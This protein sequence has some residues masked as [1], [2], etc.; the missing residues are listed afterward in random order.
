[1]ILRL[2]SLTFI[3][4]YL[5]FPV[6]A[7]EWLDE[8]DK[9]DL[10][11]EWFR[12]TD[13][14]EQQSIVEIEDGKLLLNEPNGNFGH[15]EV[16]GRPLVLRK[17]PEGDF[18]IS[19][20]IDTEPPSPAKDY[21]IGLFIIGK[22]GDHPVLAENWAILTIGGVAGDV[23]A[24]IG[25]M[26]NNVWNDKGHFGIPEWPIYLKLDKVGIQ[27]TGYYKEK[28]ADEWTM[29]GASWNHDGMEEPELCGLGFVN[30]WGGA[31]LTLMAEYFLLEGEN[32]SS[33]A[34]QPMDK[35]STAWGRIKLYH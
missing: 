21:W 29:V 12:I 10:D 26:I 13:R 23:T 8:F 14:P 9:D 4:A 34:V 2:I 3:L 15:T 31:N 11:E 35:L 1:V 24:M 20:L 25:S 30:S 32:V 6:L 27:Y 17:A 19:M 18:S 28:P 7:G 16:N 22:D 33:M 5:S